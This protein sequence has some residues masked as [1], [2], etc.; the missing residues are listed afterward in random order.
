[1]HAYLKMYHYPPS[2]CSLHLRKVSLSIPLKPCL[3]PQSSFLVPSGSQDIF[4][5]QHRTKDTLN[6]IV[7][8]F[9]LLPS[10]TVEN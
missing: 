6:H 1:M 2:Q 5:G 4:L 8:L 7:T 10:K 3:L 9:L